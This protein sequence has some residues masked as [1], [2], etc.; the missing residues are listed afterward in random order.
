M[1]EIK[2]SLEDV[3]HV[4][5]L[6]RLHLSDDEIAVMRGQLNAILE[7]MASLEE[8]DV[9]NVKPT[10]YSVALQAPLRPDAIKPSLRHDE[11]LRA[12]P[13]QKAGAFAVPK[14]MDGDG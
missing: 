11:A 1:A 7:Y 4:A 9:K 8:L 5:E 10:F 6:A 13:A 12:A 2:I 14:V 3:R